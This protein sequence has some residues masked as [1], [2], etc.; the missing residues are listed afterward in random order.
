[1]RPPKPEPA[2]DPSQRASGDPGRSDRAGARL[3]GA[4]LAGGLAV[5]AGWVLAH[6][7]LTS[8]PARAGVALGALAAVLVSAL[9]GVAE[10]RALRGDGRAGATATLAAMA[11][12]FLAKLL[13]LA[14]GT[15]VL[16]LR[17]RATFHPPAF[18]IAFAGA[19]FVFHVTSTFVLVR[20][21]S[22][23]ERT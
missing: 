19:S 18:A 15:I 2:G 16:H 12:G 10:A 20:R 4:W 14:A 11:L 22:A 23:A 6:Y 3:R 7:A 13:V 8:G 5:L 1:V 9:G 17:A 21:R